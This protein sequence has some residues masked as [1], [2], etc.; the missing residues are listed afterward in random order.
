MPSEYALSTS[1]IL[2]ITATLASVAGVVLIARQKALGWPLGMLWA[3]ISAWLAFA[4]WHLISDGILYL[5]YIP[6]QAY[7]WHVWKNGDSGHQPLTPTWMTRGNQ[8]RL[9]G[10][11]LLSILLW[12]HAVQWAAR[13]ISWVP[14]PSLLWAD[15][16]TTVLNYGAQWLQARKRMENWIGW[17]IVNLMGIG[18]YLRIESPIYATQYALFFLLGLYGWWCWGKT[19]RHNP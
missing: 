12:G 16:T 9:I 15:T 2:E 3:A 14:Q 10:T 13:H 5:S 4:Q 6:I 7:C 8:L 17:A 18:I 19:P 11:L 1:Q